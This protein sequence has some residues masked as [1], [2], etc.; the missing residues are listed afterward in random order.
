MKIY[1]YSFIR[2][3]EPFLHSGQSADIFIM[4]EKVGY[5]GSV[6]PAV[7]DVLDIKAHK[8]AVVVMEL[9]I[10]KLMPYTMQVVKYRALPKYPHVERDTALVVDS[11]IEASAIVAWLKSYASDMIEDIHIF[12]VY[13]GKNIP[14]GKKSIAFN[15]RY[16]AAG[17]TLKD[18]EVDAL[19]KSLVD[20]ILDKTN[21]QLR[22]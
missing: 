15:V 22:Q 9:D 5:V 1:D 8:P 2:S 19:H 17:R 3:S 12:D 13:Q 6:S 11:S 18:E 20:Y 10:D 7:I 16:R 21:G 4:D 14:E